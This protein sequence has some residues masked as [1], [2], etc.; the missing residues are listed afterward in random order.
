MGQI[1][2]SCLPGLLERVPTGT[3]ARERDLS[4]RQPAVVTVPG[5]FVLQSLFYRAEL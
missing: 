5:D 4:R 1:V 3:V 2:A